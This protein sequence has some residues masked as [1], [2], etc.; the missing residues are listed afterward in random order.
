MDFKLTKDEAAVYTGTVVKEGKPIAYC[1]ASKRDKK[2]KKV[3][4][5]ILVI[6]M[7]ETIKKNQT[8]TE[9]IVQQKVTMWLPVQGDKEK[10]ADFKKRLDKVEKVYKAAKEGETVEPIDGKIDGVEVKQT[11][12]TRPVKDTQIQIVEQRVMEYGKREV[13][14]TFPIRLTKRQVKDFIKNK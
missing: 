14:E 10:D 8:E 7:E 5:R 3:S 13:L 1:Y 11:V 4:T 2:T 9:R 12:I 6:P